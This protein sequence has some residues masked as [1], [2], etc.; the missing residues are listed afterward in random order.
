AVGPS[1]KPHPPPAGFQHAADNVV[2]AVAIEVAHVDIEPGDRGG[3]L[4][5]G[6]EI[7][8]VA[9][10]QSRPPPA[11]LQHAAGDVLAAVAIEIADLDVHQ[12]DGGGPSAP[13]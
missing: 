4:V 5:P 11:G 3:P 7:E 8:R 9:G 13:A 6:R 1:R 10:T 2:L 12:G